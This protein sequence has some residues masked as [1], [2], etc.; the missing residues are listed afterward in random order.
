MFNLIERK[1][2]EDFGGAGV[3]QWRIEV[4]HRPEC[5]EDTHKC[6]DASG[7]EALQ[8]PLLTPWL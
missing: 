4:Q 8:K 3:Q 2:E 7:G 1:Y 5:E 6:E